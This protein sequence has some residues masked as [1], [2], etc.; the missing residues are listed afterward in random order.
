[1]IFGESRLKDVYRR[2]TWGP[3]RVTL[4]ALPAPAEMRLIRVLARA[5]A[6]ALP[7]RRRQLRTNLARAFPDWSDS[8]LDAASREAFAAHFSNQYISFSFSK[9]TKETWPRYIRFEGLEHLKKASEQGRGVVLMHPHMGP[10]QLPLHVLALNGY[11]MHQVGGG[12]VTLVELSD[13]GRWASDTRARLEAR[14]PVTLHDGKKYLRPLLRALS[15]GAVLMSA[16]DATGGG[17]E[18][19]RREQR[20]VLGQDYGVP[21][22][23]IWM[24]WRS[25]APLLSIRCVRNR[26]SDGALFRAIIEPEIVLDRNL[27]LKAALAHG[28]DLTAA[29]LDSILRVHPGD[30]LFWDGF[31]PGGLLPED[32]TP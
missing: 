31:R 27:P 29:W 25:G 16:C 10:A 18:L 14:M 23:P 17:S 11:D 12:E 26:S 6:R 8:Q 2:M 32:S 30:W 5:S 22:G 7:A 15:S 19:G 1:V 9:C 4:E 20:V 28:A 24:A 3:G 13:T 21:I